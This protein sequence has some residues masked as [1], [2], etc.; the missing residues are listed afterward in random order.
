MSTRTEIPIQ[1]LLTDETG[2]IHEYEDGV[3]DYGSQPLDTGIGLAFKRIASSAKGRIVYV[4]ARLPRTEPAS[5]DERRRQLGHV[6]ENLIFPLG[7]L[8]Q[9][10]FMVDCV[11]AED[12]P[13]QEAQKLL[14][15]AIA[16]IEE[17][18]RILDHEAG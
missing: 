1:V 12:D 11:M 16:Q 10:E 2:V 5:D 14:I 18:T 8:H 9:A 17:A 4:S 3:P 7:S 15:S 13:A 6:A